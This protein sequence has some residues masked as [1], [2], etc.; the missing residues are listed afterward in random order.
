MQRPANT[1]AEVRD[2][3]Q[4]MYDRQPYRTEIDGITLEIAKGVFPADAVTSTAMIMQTL[5][6]FEPTVALD[7]GCGC[8]VL[9]LHMRRLGADVV[10]ACDTS[11]VAVDCARNNAAAN[12]FNDIRVVQSDLFA[13]IPSNAR[14][15]LVVL[16][17]AYQPGDT[18]LFGPQTVSNRQ[19]VERLFDTMLPYLVPNAAVI[20]PFHEAAGAA[21]DPAALARARGYEV[22]EIT[23]VSD[24]SGNSRVVVIYPNAA[25]D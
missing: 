16:N 6:E 9:A 19:T 1:E 12:G 7:A 10:Y 11:R 4:R 23:F 5:R 13:N 22:E 24:R 15:D 21:N 25:L 18:N 2:R 20:I 8:G 14:F 3:L 17:Q